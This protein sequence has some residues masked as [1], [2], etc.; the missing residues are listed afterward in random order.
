MAM[1]RASNARKLCVIMLGEQG[2]KMTEKVV[3][4]EIH[5]VNPADYLID[6]S[7]SSWISNN[8]DAQRGVGVEKSVFVEKVT[9]TGAEAGASDHLT[10]I[11]CG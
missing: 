2:K 10:L 9:L 4:P 3:Y 7:S 1:T 11:L 6:P 8:A 5:G